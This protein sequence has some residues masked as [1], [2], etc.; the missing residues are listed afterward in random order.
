MTIAGILSGVLNP[1]G[2]GYLLTRIGARMAPMPAETCGATSGGCAAPS[3]SDGNRSTQPEDRVDWS[4][5]AQALNTVPAQSAGAAQTTPAI[6]TGEALSEEEQSEVADL[7]ERDTTVRAHEAAHLAAA[8]GYARGAAEYT[9]KAGPDGKQYA[10]GGEVQIDTSEVPDNPEA[11]VR[12][13]ET[14]RAAALAPADPSGQDRS[15]AAEA[16]AAI[17]KARSAAAQS[18][19]AGSSPGQST[20]AAQRGKS[21]A[22]GSVPESDR[23]GSQPNFAQTR[24]LGSAQSARTTGSPPSAA[25]ATAAATSTSLAAY[26]AQQNSTPRAA[27]QMLAADLDVRA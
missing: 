19:A 3:A 20:P 5:A 23:S 16:S 22:T 25:S 9:Y 17:T 21:S 12:K 2:R 14:V 13:M 15:V 7:Q 26:R 6:G 8:G 10:V 11:T 18:A 1:T 27:M 24:T 4:P